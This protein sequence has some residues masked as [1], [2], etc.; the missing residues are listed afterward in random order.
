M[1][2][3]VG[4][5]RSAKATDVVEGSVQDLHATEFAQDVVGPH[6]SPK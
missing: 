4:Q 5:H 1:P 3:D 2:N 6:L